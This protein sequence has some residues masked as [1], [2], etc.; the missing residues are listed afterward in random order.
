MQSGLRML[1]NGDDQIIM[2]TNPARK[3]SPR[4]ILSPRS[5]ASSARGAGPEVKG[6]DLDSKSAVRFAIH[7]A[8]ETFDDLC[9][10][11]TL[12]SSGAD[13]TDTGSFDEHI[14]RGRS[15]LAASHI[16]LQDYQGPMPSGIVSPRHAYSEIGT[17]RSHVASLSTSNDKLHAQVVALK[18]QLKS[19]AAAHLKEISELQSRIRE[20][21]D[22]GS[23]SK[24]AGA[25]PKKQSI[26]REGGSVVEG[27]L[28][29]YVCGVGLRCLA[30]SFYC[31]P[32]VSPHVM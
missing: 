28:D 6:G 18:A 22:D 15:D 16:D 8:E 17:L 11:G 26:P 32:V 29:L 10:S 30:H 7:K 19:Q 27:H 20:M 2:K 14:D 1:G 21:G 5:K 23:E 3:A 9:D 12:I 4:S 31:T 24:Q 25:R 13:D